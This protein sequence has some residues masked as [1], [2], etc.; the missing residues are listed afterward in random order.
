MASQETSREAGAAA[1]GRPASGRQQGGETGR[2][3]DKPDEPCAAA[4]PRGKPDWSHGLRQLY[5]S[6]LEEDLPD[7]FKDLLDRLDESDPGGADKGPPDQPP[8]RGSGA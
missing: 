8:S 1:R 6:V 2:A 7:S 4:Q 5:D 3:A